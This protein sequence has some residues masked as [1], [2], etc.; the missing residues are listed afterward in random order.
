M[1]DIICLHSAPLV[2]TAELT[3][4]HDQVGALQI[5]GRG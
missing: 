5:P 3:E 1:H 4:A 2:K